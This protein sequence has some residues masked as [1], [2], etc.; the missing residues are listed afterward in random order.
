MPHTRCIPQDQRASQAIIDARVLGAMFIEHGVNAAALKAY[1]D[2]LCA[3]VSEVV[4]R[5]RGAGPLGC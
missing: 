3:S 5:N 4:L 1:D 2:A